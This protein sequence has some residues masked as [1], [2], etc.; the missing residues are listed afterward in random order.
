[1]IPISDSEAVKLRTT[2]KQFYKITIILKFLLF[3]KKHYKLT[4]NSQ[5]LNNQENRYDK[6]FQFQNFIVKFV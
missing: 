5:K 1:M 3:Y 6:V 4:V 2:S